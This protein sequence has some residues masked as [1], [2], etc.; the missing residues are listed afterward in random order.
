MPTSSPK[1]RPTLD[2]LLRLKQAEKPDG[3]FWQQFEQDW[4]K[5]RL[6]ALVEPERP[7]RRWWVV[8][9]APSAA[10]SALALALYAAIPAFT[11]TQPEVEVAY[12]AT[13]ATPL[14]IAP[15]ATETTAP[16]VNPVI[17]AQIPTA[18][19]R[20]I[21]NALP[22]RGESSIRFRMAPTRTSLTTSSGASYVRD[23]LSATPSASVSTAVWRGAAF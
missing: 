15:V 6:Q 13:P 4:E 3:A 21:E 1:K 20:F 10:L 16:E 22:T 17:L 9:L 11:A 7:A 2:Q 18:A 5:K 14:T 19:P 12:E 23:T 8:A